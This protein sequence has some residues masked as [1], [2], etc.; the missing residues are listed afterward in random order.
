MAICAIE[1]FPSPILRKKAAKV[2]KFDKNLEKLVRDLR[3]TMHK[4]PHGI[5]IA[6]PQIGISKAGGV[7]WKKI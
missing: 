3:Q 2:S 7:R 4:Q 5:G 1:L 6:A